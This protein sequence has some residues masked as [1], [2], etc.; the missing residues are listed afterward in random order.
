MYKPV[1]KTLIGVIIFF[2]PETRLFGLKR[3]LYRQLGY[4]I[5]KNTRICSS[6]RFFINGELSIGESVWIGPEV[7]I[8]CNSGS[9]I[10]LENFCRIGM[11]SVLVTGFHD[12]TPNENC[13]QGKG[14]SS[15]I[16]LG[17]GCAV[18]T[19]STIL[20]GKT[21]GKMAHVAAGSVVTRDVPDYHRVG[22]VPAKFLKDLREML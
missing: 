8:S 19:G 5:G 9:K 21:I 12:I 20:P 16:V 10:I 17:S 11:R 2:I 4:K 3:F 6:V 22:G 1:F 14:T 13:I 15:T 7:I 18:S